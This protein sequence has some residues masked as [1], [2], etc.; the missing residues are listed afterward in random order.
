MLSTSILHRCM[1]ICSH[2]T[3]PFCTHDTKVYNSRDTHRS[4]QTW[5][6]RQCVS[7]N[8]AFTT[9]E[10]VDY[11]GIISIRTPVDEKPYSRERLF[12]SLVRASDKLE[13]PADMLSELTDSIELELQQNHFFETS[14]RDATVIVSIA[15]TI[16]HRYDT[17]LALQYVNN[18]YSNKPPRELLGQLLEPFESS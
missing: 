12:L 11:N 16:L 5:R 1:T 8:K 17:N 7:C 13:L 14:P 10:K 9:R 2:M 4:T 6:R 3:C 15:T 18:V